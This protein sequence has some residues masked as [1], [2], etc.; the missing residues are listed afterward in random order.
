M[1]LTDELVKR[2]K[3]P[4]AGQRFLWDDLVAGF[5]VRLT[6]TAAAFVI[7]WRET[8]GKKPRETFRPR[9]PQ[10][11]V[12]DAR[13]RARSRLSE[14][15]TSREKG[16][17]V[18]LR[19]AMRSWYELHTTRGTWRPRY[20]M[21]I[22]S[23][24]STY[25]EGI[26]NPRVKLSRSAADA[27][28]DLSKR[29]IGATTRT[30][31]LAVADHIKAGTAEQFMAVLSSF[32]N[33]AMD[34]EWVAGNPARNRLKVFGGRTKRK[35][36]PTD[37]EFLELWNAFKGEGDPAFSAFAILAF[38]GA[39]RREVTQM[40]WSE[41]DVAQATWT[42]PPER[43]K[44]GRKDPIPFV[45]NLHPDA[46]AAITRQPKLQ[47]SPFVFWGRRD[48][49]PFDF[50]S[51]LMV[52]IRKL[53][54]SNDWRL[55]DIRR[56]MRSGLSALRVSETVAELCLGHKK[57][58]LVDVYDQHL[59]VQEKREAWTKWGDYLVALVQK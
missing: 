52:R 55:H 32:F 41:V 16:A 1:R 20:R 48:E 37:A 56:Y 21:K 33:H 3:R 58:G 27:I 35:N 45:I 10:L 50:H 36:T 40:R 13:A 44:T 34:R 57:A 22:D 17:D 26:P 53:V 23:I 51:A 46:L 9:W 4:A 43:R 6:P 24:I 11:T 5:G 59:F 7:Q 49:R 2:T 14:V 18:P 54:S 28:A 31:I 42:L 38:T 25:V 29:S 15:T 39:R 12:S 19:V 30:D 47:G 8:G